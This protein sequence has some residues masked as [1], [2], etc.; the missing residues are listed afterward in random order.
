MSEVPLSR[1][2]VFRSCSNP[3]K[4]ENLGCRLLTASEV[5][6]LCRGIFGLTNHPGVELRANLKSISHRYH[7]FEVACVW[8]LTKKKLAPGLLPG[9]FGEPRLVPAPNLMDLCRKPSM[10]T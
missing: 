10:S 9:R 6:Q 4:M 7:L 3:P 2:T 5:F 1:P 8:E